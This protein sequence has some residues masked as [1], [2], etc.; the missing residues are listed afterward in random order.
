MKSKKELA[1][2]LMKVREKSIKRLIA[3]TK[4]ENI[5]I[6]KPPSQALIMAVAN[7]CFNTKFCLGEV[8]VT[9][10]QIEWKGHRGFGMIIGNEPQKALV[11]AFI[12]AVEK[13]DDERTKRTVQNLIATVE[14]RQS[15]RKK[16]EEA[17]ILSTRV[18][19]ETMVKR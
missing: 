19:F 18:N 2:L 7:D 5:K 3:L 9:E 14:R 16:V 15:K 1:I 10:A 6:I 11:L 12:D 4:R 8:L 13:S 17:M